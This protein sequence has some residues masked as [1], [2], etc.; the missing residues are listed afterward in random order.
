M[1]QVLFVTGK[2]VLLPG[3]DIPQPATLKIDVGSGKITDIQYK[4][5]VGSNFASEL[6]I[7]WIDAGDRFI[8]PGLVE[9]VQLLFAHPPPLTTVLQCARS[10]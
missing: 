2:N 10:P 8:L 4:H 7:K 5:I 6:P 9:W 3:S 1:A